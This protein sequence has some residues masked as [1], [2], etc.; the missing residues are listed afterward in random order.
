MTTRK[1]TP[2]TPVNYLVVRVQ[3]V[4]VRRGLLGLKDTM[5]GYRIAIKETP[6]QAERLATKLF[7]IM[8][9]DAEKSGDIE[10]NPR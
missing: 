8:D 4:G 6:A 1:N 5:I 2:N 3:I 10:V 7:E 9:E